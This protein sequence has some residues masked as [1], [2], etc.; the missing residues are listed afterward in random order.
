LD[1]SAGLGPYFRMV[2]GEDMKKWCK[3]HK[4][5][6]GDN[7]DLYRDGLRIYTTINPRM[8]MYA[9]EAVAKH[10]SFMQQILNTQ[11]NIK[12]G[13]IWKNFESIVES[14]MKQ[15]DRWRNLKKKD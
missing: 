2:L 6:N 12:S 10:M 9:E 13:S 5:P 8:Q 14:A 11:E 1:E 3:N 15:S 7:Y 4:K